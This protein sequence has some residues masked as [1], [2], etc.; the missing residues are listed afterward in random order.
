MKIDKSENP[1]GNIGWESLNPRHILLDPAWK[2]NNVND[3][4]NY[5]VF[6]DLLPTQIIELYPEAADKL[7]KQM[8]FDKAED[9]VDFGTNNGAVDDHSAWEKKWGSYQRVIEFHSITTRQGWWEWDKKNGC[10]FPDTGYK[11]DSNEDKMS[12]LVYIQTHGLGA[13][14]VAMVPRTWHEAN[15]ETCVPT[16]SNAVF[17]SKGLD[18]VQTGN[19][20]L[21]P[22]GIRYNGQFQGVVVDR[23]YDLQIA[24]NRGE[25]NRQ[26][27]MTRSAK[28]AFLL[29][30]ALAG[31]DESKK[32]IIEQEWNSPSARI[33][34]DE[35]TTKNLG[36]NGGIVPL[37][38]SNVSFDQVNALSNYHDMSDR[39]S[40][41]PASMD[42]RQESAKESGKLFQSKYNAGL[43]AQK[44]LMK[45]VEQHKKD[46]A[47][48]Y[49]DQA[50][51]LYSNGTRVFA[52]TKS[53]KPIVINTTN[54]DKF[55]LAS[56]PR[57]KISVVPSPNGVSVRNEQR[58]EIGEI[59]SLLVGP[60]DQLMKSVQLK[61]LFTLAEM[62]DKDREE[63]MRAAE[64]TVLANAFDLQARIA[65]SQGMIA[66]SAPQQAPL[67]PGGQTPVSEGQPPKIEQQISQS[68]P[69]PVGAQGAI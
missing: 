6:N 40:K 9:K 56:I 26:D 22:L 20:N 49:Y 57:L 37:P 65:Q 29:D 32:A 2:T 44:F 63:M 46:K 54:D 62:P 69:A 1:F 64:M 15:I 30:E 53:G 25:M 10:F 52:G 28:G 42:A 33:W 58:N 68:Q 5:I 60:N 35:G 12:K 48:A 59:L 31:G 27:V 21:Y 50:K 43:I 4:K 36:P 13:N 66:Q 7:L 3:L 61:R 41:V 39:F 51:I 55:D 16:L 11:Q 67:P 8:D 47:F 45:I 23:L 18:P 24:I 14:D 17:L 34:V 38:L 19:V